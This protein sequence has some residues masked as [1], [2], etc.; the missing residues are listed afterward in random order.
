MLAERAGLE[1]VQVSAWPATVDKV[2][3]A[4]SE[5]IGV[6]P[7]EQPN[8]VASREQTNVLWLGPDRW[9]IVKPAESGRDLVSEL[10]ERLPSDTAA[11]VELSAGR[12]VFAISG[13]R[14][15]GVLAK[16]LPLDLSRSNFPSGR[17]AQSAMAHIGVLV[18]AEGE[19]AFEIFV[20]RGFARHLW[21]ILTDAA[22]EFRDETHSR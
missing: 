3:Q 22:L 15:R 9:L 1:M 21:E 18:H 13:A 4:L 14:S 7:P 2:L 8:T 6:Y 12:C 16:Y 19:D 5:I 11:V 10:A 17:C 20:Y